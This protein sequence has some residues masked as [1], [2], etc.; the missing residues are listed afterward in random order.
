MHAVQILQNLFVEPGQ[1]FID[2]HD[3]VFTALVALLPV[4]TSFA[5]FTLI[6]FLGTAVLVPLHRFCP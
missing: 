5:V 2:P 3:T 4:K 6:I 1:L